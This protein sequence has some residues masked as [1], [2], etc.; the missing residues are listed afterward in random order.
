MIHIALTK[1]NQVA[2]E[3]VYSALYR[4]FSRSQV[5]AD[6]GALCRVII[7]PDVEDMD[8]L[9]SSEKKKAF[10]KTFLSSISC[11]AKISSIFF[12]SDKAIQAKMTSGINL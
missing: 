4:S 1:K 10:S 6:G 3:L 11:T 8:I 2:G 12:P 9:F 7:N 5:R